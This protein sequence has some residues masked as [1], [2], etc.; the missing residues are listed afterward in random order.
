MFIGSGDM[1]SRPKIRDQW[2]GLF[3]GREVA[4]ATRMSP[5]RKHGPLSFSGMSLED[6]AGRL[7]G[8]PHHPPAFEQ[9]DEV[10]ADVDLPPE[11]ALVGRALIAVVVI[12]PAFAKSDEGHPQVVAALVGSGITPAAE[13]MTHRVHHE[14]R[15]V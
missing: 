9:L 15:V 14:D 5:C 12:V 4:R 13:E 10:V 8:C 3:R 7:A 11:K 2:Q 6:V 1:L